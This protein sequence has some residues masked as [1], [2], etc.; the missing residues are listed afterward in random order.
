MTD[1]AQELAQ[2][3]GDGPDPLSFNLL[4]R[5]LVRCGFIVRAMPYLMRLLVLHE[6][7]VKRGEPIF[8]DE[9]NLSAMCARV[10]NRKGR[11]L[12]RCCVWPVR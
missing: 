4:V 7:H 3:Q 2:R 8:M 6:D 5:T 12:G 10:I 1:I 11:G 9:A